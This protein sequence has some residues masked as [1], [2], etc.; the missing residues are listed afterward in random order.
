MDVKIRLLK[1]TVSLTPELCINAWEKLGYTYWDL[2]IS[3]YS[4]SRDENIFWNN[5]EYSIFHCSVFLV[6]ILISELLFKILQHTV[7]LVLFCF[8][9]LFSKKQ[10][11]SRKC[12]S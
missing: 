6:I 5:V 8:V 11:D 7:L 1:P 3:L 2:S 12:P 9:L 4:L 10:A